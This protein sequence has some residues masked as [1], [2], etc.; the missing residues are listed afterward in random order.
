MMCVRV[1]GCVCV[2]EEENGEGREKVNDR[3]RKGVAVGECASVRGVPRRAAAEMGQRGSD[4]DSDG[5][6][7]DVGGT[8]W[9]W[10]GTAQPGCGCGRVFAPPLRPAMRAEIVSRSPSKN[11][12]Q[13]SAGWAVAVAGESCMDGSCLG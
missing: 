8:A 9:L 3:H 1:C 2:V 7:E 5:Q 6:D 12:K 13:S 4:S 10:V 11:T